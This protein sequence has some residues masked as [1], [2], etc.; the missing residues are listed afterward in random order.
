LSPAR[1]LTRLRP[2]LPAGQAAFEAAS[3]QAAFC[4]AL[5]ASIRLRQR[6]EIPMPG[7]VERASAARS[8][9]D[10]D[11]GRPLRV[12]IVEDEAAL[13]ADLRSLLAD[14]GHHVVGTVDSGSAALSV[15]AERRPDLVLMDVRL[16]DGTDGIEVAI[17]LRNRWGI[18]SIFMSAFSDTDTKQR[19]LEARPYDWLEKPFASDSVIDTVA[20]IAAGLSRRH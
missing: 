8:G 19:A 18:P 4:P 20:R 17:D 6:K 2:E 16:T 13:A 14:F 5:E 7:C 12:L 10:E 9:C 1:G 15:A 11:A 3:G